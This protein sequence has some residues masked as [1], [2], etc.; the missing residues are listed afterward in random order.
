M[1]QRGWLFQIHMGKNLKLSF[2]S[3]LRKCTYCGLKNKILGN[4]YTAIVLYLCYFKS[5]IGLKARVFVEEVFDHDRFVTNSRVPEWQR[6]TLVTPSNYNNAI[7]SMY[8]D[9]IHFQLIL[10]YCLPLNEISV[11]HTICWIPL[12]GVHM[13]MI[14]EHLFRLSRGEDLWTISFSHPEV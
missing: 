3:Y 5:H 2:V 1:Q 9:L 12:W 13:R 4:I 14:S 8:Y 11:K 7:V 6:L 10:F